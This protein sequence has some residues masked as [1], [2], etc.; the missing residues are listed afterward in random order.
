MSTRP[1][2]IRN[3]GID[4]S[5]YRII[6]PN[7]EG[8]TVDHED[9]F[10][11]VSLVARTKGKSVLTNTNT[12]NTSTVENT[13]F[14]TIDFVTG[15]RKTQ[16]TNWTEIGG[17]QLSASK[18]NI[19]KDLEGFGI[20]NID[21]NIKGNY[22]PKVVIDFVDVRGATLF[23]QGSCSQYGVFF[24]LPYPVFELTVKGYYGQPVKYFLNLVK[25]NTKFNAETGNFESRGEFIGW[26]Y[27]FLADMLIGMVWASGYMRDWNSLEN[28]GK[29]YEN[30]I[31]YYD[32]NNLLSEDLKTIYNGG[33]GSNPFCPINPETGKPK[34][35]TIKDLLFDINKIEEALG[36]LKQTDKYKE[37][38]NLLSVRNN[39]QDVNEQIIK[40]SKEVRD[41]LKTDKDR[42]VN[43]FADGRKFL[44]ER[45]EWEV[46]DGN[47]LPKEI[48]NKFLEYFARTGDQ[49]NLFDQP[50]NTGITGPSPFN[51]ENVKT[52]K[53]IRTIMR[54]LT[55]QVNDDGKCLK[56]ILKNSFAS[57]YDSCEIDDIDD[58]SKI[59]DRI[60]DN[61]QKGFSGGGW[62]SNKT[63]SQKQIYHVDLGYLNKEL[64]SISV[65]LKDIIQKRRDEI[66]EGVNNKLKEILGFLPTI[67]NVFTILACN[68]ENFMD[69]LL[70]CNIKAEVH[71]EERGTEYASD[72]INQSNT[73]NEAYD[74][75]DSSFLKVYS[76]PTYQTKEIPFG[77][78][79]PER[80]EKYPGDTIKYSN[81]W[82]VQFVEDFL[83]A[84]LEANRDAEELQSDGSFDNY[85]SLLPLESPYFNEGSRPKVF[86]IGD[87][88]D[89]NDSLEGKIKKNII[90]RIFTLTH[91]TTFDPINL[92]KINVSLGLGPKQESKSG[93]NYSK[94]RFPQ[95]E[96]LNSN[97]RN[98]FF[99][100]G[101]IDA[102]N[103]LYAIPEGESGLE[104]IR[105]ISDEIKKDLTNF[106]QL[107]NDIS[108]F[109][110]ISTGTLS[111]INTEWDGIIDDKNNITQPTGIYYI[112]KPT[113]GYI[114]AT[115]DEKFKIYP[116][117]SEMDQ[118][119]LFQ[120][121]E[122][123]S[124]NNLQIEDD[125][126]TNV[127]N[128][129]KE[130]KSGD[131]FKADYLYGEN[132]IRIDTTN[133]T[134]F[135]DGSNQSNRTMFIS[136]NIGF[137]EGENTTKP[138]DIETMGVIGGL[139]PIINSDNNKF[140]ASIGGGERVWGVAGSAQLTQQEISDASLVAPTLELPG[141]GIFKNGTG[142][143][144]S[145]ESYGKSN[146][147][148]SSIGEDEIGRWGET[149]VFDTL[150]MS[151]I[152]SDNV[153]RFRRTTA[154]SILE[155]RVNNVE[156]DTELKDSPNTNTKYTPDQIQ[157]RNLAYLFLNTLKPTPFITN[158]SKRN[159][160]ESE[161]SWENTYPKS[162]DAFNKLGSVVKTPKAWVLGMGA[163]LWRWK[164]FMGT[165]TDNDNNIIW[166]HPNWLGNRGQ[167][168]QLGFD[169]LA[170]PGHPT[171]YTSNS[172][173][174]NRSVTLD[175][176]VN[177]QSLLVQ[178][179]LLDGGV[180]SSVFDPK[181]TVP[182]NQ[183]VGGVASTIERDYDGQG[184]YGYYFDWWGYYSSQ[185]SLSVPQSRNFDG[186]EPVWNNYIN[187]ISQEI[188]GENK[189]Q[190]L[191]ALA[192]SVVGD[193][194]DVIEDGL[195]EKEI[196]IQQSTDSKEVTKKSYWGY[197][198]ITPWQH[199]YTETVDINGNVFDKGLDK[200]LSFI[201][202]NTK[203]R[204]Y[205]GSFFGKNWDSRD[206]LINLPNSIEKAETITINGSDYNFTYNKIGSDKT[207]QNIEGRYG[208]FIALLPDFVKDRLIEVFENW[209]D[210]EWS[211]NLLEIVDPV[212]FSDT[213]SDSLSK[214][215]ILKAFSDTDYGDQLFGQ[216]KN[217]LQ[218]T[219]YDILSFV[220]FREDV[221]SELKTQLLD[222]NYIILNSTPKLF[223]L[224][225]QKY[226]GFVANQ[227]L[228]DKYLQGFNEILNSDVFTRIEEKLDNSTIEEANLFGETAIEDNDVKLS[229]YRTFKSI[230]DKWISTSRRGGSGDDTEMFFNIL[231]EGSSKKLNKGG[232]NNESVTS[233]EKKS[234][235]KPL[236]A[237]FSFVNRVMDDIGNKAI[238]DITTLK[239]IVDN[240][241]I[242]LYQLVTDL[243]Q[244][245]GF[246]FF[247]L[248][249]FTNFA[250]SD[251]DEAL[252]SMFE[253][254]TGSLPVEG[255][256]NFICMYVGGTSRMLDLKP[257][258]NCY[259]DD[260]DLNYAND[261]FSLTR[262]L[263]KRPE[264][265]S[266]EEGLITED[267]TV[268]TSSKIEQ[269]FTD[270]S[271][272][273]EGKGLTAF[274]VSYG[275][276][277]Q[278]HFKNIQLDQ[279]EFSETNES[280]S[281]ID[282]LGKK[283]GDGEGAATS[284]G[285]N[286]HNVYLTRSYTCKVESLGNMTI[287]PLQ[288][289]ELSNVPMFHGTY[290]I[291]E[292]SHDVKPHHVSTNFTGVRQPIATV[293][294]VT[295][296]AT[297]MKLTLKD[298]KTQSSE[299]LSFEDEF[300]GTRTV[301]STSNLGTRDRVK[302][303]GDISKGCSGG[304]NPMGV[305]IG[306]N[307]GT[308]GIVED[309]SNLSLVNVP[310]P[311][312]GIPLVNVSEPRMLSEAVTPLGEMLKDLKEHLLSL[313]WN[314]NKTIQIGS[315]FRSISKQEELRVE[316]GTSA[317]VPGT[318]KHGLGIA[319][320][321]G[322][323]EK[324][325]TYAEI[326]KMT[327]RNQTRGFQSEQY[328]WLFFN[329]YLYGFVP[330]ESLRNG[331]TDEWWHWEYVGTAAYSYMAAYPIAKNKWINYEWK[332]A[333]GKPKYFEFVTNPVDVK[334]G[335]QAILE[336]GNTEA[337]PNNLEDVE[338]FVQPLDPS[339]PNYGKGIV[340]SNLKQPSYVEKLK[341]AGIIDKQTFGGIT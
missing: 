238:L 329:S 341:N 224:V 168:D 1:R 78:G 39:L 243:L 144:S 52:G 287:Q 231:G 218:N 33:Q 5:R 18:E 4:E 256:P 241:K 271:G 226:D 115:D 211:D 93:I 253:P 35:I 65:E 169:P 37:L 22:I 59:L 112:Y 102:L 240:P 34:C 277:N 11:F 121:I 154:G 97:S 263:N 27:A 74:N 155:S 247:P 44:K 61:F 223:N 236:A 167:R 42:L 323:Y 284:K 56:D 259:I 186:D 47:P 318:S 204:D 255:G 270:D 55:K 146:S 157:D 28:L 178:V 84:L 8:H 230:S 153:N 321:L 50:E 294:V 278:N 228:V 322:F 68:T 293:P 64:D 162:L 324:D 191:L 233:S 139:Y 208:D 201:P 85:V 174:G 304:G 82:E 258:T 252:I 260:V 10:T 303:V 274:R 262:D 160:I 72:F 49:I 283:G 336:C 338:E 135:Y 129:N 250:N 45:L 87:N 140:V 251:N 38:Q 30:T 339:D 132:P 193:D 75:K 214:S 3:S 163:T 328:K 53:I 194:S 337:T 220:S 265:F 239:K 179:G 91:H 123:E 275:L 147:N 257:K 264:E 125:F 184:I 286:L 219:N 176:N 276:E 266:G 210:N 175:S 69:I 57:S 299:T 166:R 311:F 281:I 180:Q 340:V 13:E 234:T 16:S 217:D 149:S 26:S 141:S 148:F 227:Q 182:G 225:Y 54:L 202:T 316:Y 165:T 124:I 261:S 212:N 103:L 21:I 185:P 71:H 216:N 246:D 269:A 70:T 94:N 83:R 104:T 222:E 197:M 108:G 138:S 206:G 60:D 77:G 333:A 105:L 137:P 187:F 300:G 310:N 88:F 315:L 232:N 317:A 188:Y 73:V 221:A 280:L 136:F 305:L 62:A 327:N 161:V 98:L 32:K 334:T 295:D 117:H 127:E 325:G 181:I 58:G 312:N 20:T 15:N 203:K 151:P 119:H 110:E 9:L 95:Y 14:R 159:G 164:N 156:S 171:Q 301:T 282:K 213:G 133:Y 335:K 7:P 291:T 302:F 177:G 285:T 237:H 199:L 66:K 92:N 51:Q 307:G 190:S 272:R 118:K 100:M 207:S 290:L 24:H 308:N 297:A 320:D 86:N 79:K 80:K 25:F 19:G 170:Q 195:V 131:L 313:G 309:G 109:G 242:S 205:I 2:I 267:N 63:N 89:S 298:I 128:L 90:E 273:I 254:Q 183:D 314:N 29:V 46:E 23:E 43:S 296:A 111:T 172:S 143:E 173:R 122:E 289:F 12:P 106:N 196:K 292:V 158:G 245:N 116:N 200:H 99:N 126:K 235:T 40:F 268:S 145:E 249:T 31:N 81:W 48:N 152:W 113:T 130:F 76:W 192:R 101:K 17:S 198:W 134:L 209:V 41:V 331:G 142:F 326:R 96:N 306:S 120:I 248:P 107:T 244:S 279:S 319:V 36:K 229:L 6:D 215:Y 114:T 67:R 330:R 288:Y 150:I 332:P 189:D